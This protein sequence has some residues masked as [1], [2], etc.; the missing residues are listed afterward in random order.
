MKTL[1]NSHSSQKSVPLG[2]TQSSPVLWWAAMGAI[3]VVAAI[4]CMGQWMLS[5]DFKPAPVGADQPTDALKAWLLALEIIFP[6]AALTFAW[7]FI[8]KPW[9]RD[10]R[11]SWDGMFLLACFSIWLQDPMDNYFIFTF[12]YNGLMTNFS[13]WAMFLPG[14]EAP[15]QNNFAEPIFMMGGLFFCTFFAMSVFGCW[16]LTQCKTRL[17]SMSV[18]GHLALLFCAFFLIDLTAESFLCYTQVFAYVAVYSPLTLWAGTPHQFPLYESFGIA[19]VCLGMTAIRYFRDDRGHSFVERGIDQ[20]KLPSAAKSGLTFLSLIG[21]VQV[22]VFF[23]FFVPYTWF[24]LKADSFPP[25]PSYQI[26]EI[27]GA[28]TPYACPSGEVP[29]PRRQSLAISPDDPRLSTQ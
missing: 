12:T 14:W 5:P 2:G 16:F 27:C 26:L 23:G 13:S 6:V 1:S 28:G 3:V 21:A 10:G 18:L 25:R 11:I 22:L 15:R 20:L 7:Q 8:V 24:A 17:P 29:M 19:I 4:S 9:A